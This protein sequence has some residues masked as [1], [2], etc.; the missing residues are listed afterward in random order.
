MAVDTQEKPKLGQNPGD[1][2][3]D[4]EFN[5]PT[6]RLDRQADEN[7]RGY[8]QD[9]EEAAD[10]PFE[11]PEGMFGKKQAADRREWLAQEN[12][13]KGKKKVEGKSSN[14]RGNIIGGGLAGGAIGIAMTLF[15]FLPAFK[16]PG[17]MSMIT[18]QVGN[19]VEHVTTRRAKIIVARAVLERFGVKGGPVITGRGPINSLIATLRTNK[20]EERLAQ[21][22]LTITGDSRGVRLIT[23]DGFQSNLLKNESEI[24]KFLGQN[25]GK[26]SNKAISQLVKEDI[27][28]WRILKRAKYARWLRL[29]Y[30]IPRFGREKTRA[31]SKDS[32]LDKETK[33]VRAT[34]SKE[35][36]QSVARKQKMYD[37]IM[38]IT[39]GDGK[40]GDGKENTA[41]KSQADDVVKKTVSQK[42]TE[43][44]GVLGKASTREAIEVMSKVGLKVSV[45]FASKAI[46]IYGWIMLYATVY[47]ALDVVYESARDGSMSQKF[48][49]IRGSMLA[50]VYGDF[51]GLGSQYQLGEQ[52]QLLMGYDSAKFD[53]VQ[54]SYTYNCIDKDFQ[55]GCDQTGDRSGSRIN[56]NIAMDDIYSVA[57]SLSGIDKSTVKTFDDFVYIKTF[58]DRKL[59][60]ALFWID[61]N[62]IGAGIQKL[63]EGV[64]WVAGGIIDIIPGAKQ[65]A[66]DVKKVVDGLTDQAMDFTF[67]LLGLNVN[68]LAFGPELFNNLFAGGV[69]SMTNY[70]REALGCHD[71]ST[72]VAVEQRDRFAAEKADYVKSKGLAYALFSPEVSSSVTT[73]LAVSVPSSASSS[74]GSQVVRSMATV[75]S[76]IPGF[77]SSQISGVSHANNPVTP[78]SLVGMRETGFTNEELDMPVEDGVLYEENYDCDRSSNPMCAADKLLVETISVCA[79]P[80]KIESPE[81]NPDSENEGPGNTTSSGAPSSGDSS[82]ET[83][84]S[85]FAWPFGE[86]NFKKYRSDYIGGHILSGS[87]VYSNSTNP[88]LGAASDISQGMKKSGEKIFAMY[89]GTVKDAPVFGQGGLSIE[90]DIGGKSMIITYM[91]GNNVQFSKGQSVKAGDHIMDMAM[92]GFGTG[93]H[94]H[95]QFEYDNTPLCI[96]DLFIAMEKG[97]TI[98]LGDRSKFPRANP[99]CSGR[100]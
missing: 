78:A 10:N 27:P 2:H 21:K 70:C 16:I 72:A 30:G 71:I 24:L 53:D 1:S 39:F 69:F 62:T 11:Y 22:G 25:E 91:H 4:D 51:A 93:E 43:V 28:T 90:S 34:A 42:A 7:A 83:T 38:K 33:A 74:T 99:G 68:D 8:A 54:K 9:R 18:D 6:S 66:A 65:F 84:A 50:S 32:E 36:D 49:D 89:G 48:A 81:C 94:L 100:R 41:A 35:V 59:A 14:L 76:S 55:S 17:I 3:Y 61:S 57:A 13:P 12:D 20:F 82:T 47:S 67:G 97:G 98:N 85:G 88:I 37:D 92:V 19:A 45:S 31:D 63:A 23:T 56:E 87:R 77:F 29:K 64:T 79:D 52:D 5:S 95:I 44:K 26:L 96:Q 80:S 46:P 86:A 73:K 58:V 60:R 40:T 75:L 15:G